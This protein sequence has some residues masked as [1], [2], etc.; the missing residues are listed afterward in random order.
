[1][2]NLS[3]LGCCAF[4]ATALFLTGCQQMINPQKPVT[5]SV[6]ADNQFQLQGKIG[7]RTPQQTGSAFF[8]W[9]QQQEEFD[10]ELSGILGVGKTRFL[11][12]R[13]K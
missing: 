12:P 8:T 2:R 1:M 11:A 13:G 4:A 7:V 9:V 3:Q 6:Q 10:I 5:P